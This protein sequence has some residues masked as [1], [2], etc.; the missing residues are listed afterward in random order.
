MQ[1][2]EQERG[3]VPME[4]EILVNELVHDQELKS[5]INK[6]LQDKRNSFESAYMPRI[7][8]ISNFIESELNRFA[9]K[10][11]QQL[12]IESDYNLLT[13]FFLKVLDSGYDT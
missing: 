7:E 9:G 8:V 5:S 13:P 6:L 10:A 12:K 4:F 1:W 3:I 2:I 11:Q